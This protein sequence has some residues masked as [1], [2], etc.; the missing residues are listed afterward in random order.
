MRQKSVA[1]TTFVILKG[2]KSLN[3]C[4]EILRK[5][6]PQ[7]NVTRP[8]NGC[9]K[10]HLYG[11][12][13][14]KNF[15]L[16][17]LINGVTAAVLGGVGWLVAT[18]FKWDSFNG[19]L[20]S[21]LGI[22]VFFLWLALEGNDGDGFLVMLLLGVGFSALLAVGWAAFHYLHWIGLIA[23][24]LFMSIGISRF[25]DLTEDAKKKGQPASNTAVAKSVAR[26]QRKQAKKG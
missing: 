9:R 20:V 6:S 19:V 3:A 13:T 22:I 26:N 8:V 5:L 17:L 25:V 7:W 23:V 16:W 21:C 12:I 14:M 18:V 10:I 15:L 2:V 1:F 4:F 11:V 24:V